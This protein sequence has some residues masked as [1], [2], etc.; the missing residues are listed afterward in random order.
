[1]AR[2]DTTQAAVNTAR[3][4]LIN[5][6]VTFVTSTMPPLHDA[7]ASAVNTMD[8]QHPMLDGLSAEDAR[9]YAACAR[10]VTE[11]R[12]KGRYSGGAYRFP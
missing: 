5:S 12:T 9:F 10:Y 11:L 1:M 3:T 6:M 8:P 2:T 7:L 4:N